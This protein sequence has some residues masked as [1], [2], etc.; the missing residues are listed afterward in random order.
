MASIVSLVSKASLRSG[1]R[2][3]RSVR[4]VY[5]HACISACMCVWVSVFLCDVSVTARVGVSCIFE[6]VCTYACIALN[7]HI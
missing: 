1:V 7:V 4:R 2:A 6:R 3:C 5:V